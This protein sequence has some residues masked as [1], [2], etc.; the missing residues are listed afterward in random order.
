MPEW[1][2]SPLSAW[3]YDVLVVDPPW[4][5]RTWSETNQAKSA[6]RHYDLMTIEQ[7][8]SLPIRM[9]AKP[10]ALL[11]LWGTGAMTPQALDVMKAWGFTYKS[12]MV[13]RKTTPSG[14]VRMGTGYWAR[15][16]HEP[17]F[18]GSIGKPR[19][20]TAFPSLF[21]GI[22]REHSRKPDEF[23]DIVMRHAPGKR[24][25][26]IFS[27]ETREGWEAWGNETGK[28]DVTHTGGPKFIGVPLEEPA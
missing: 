19:K 3:S 2:F 4:R 22:A 21:D 10:D 15:S 25:C 17:V 16:M 12:H 26:D 5:F 1:F 6:S 27:R 20:I 14:K 7:I 9:L 28:F 11:L 13:W 8:K 18:I 23:Y 24:R